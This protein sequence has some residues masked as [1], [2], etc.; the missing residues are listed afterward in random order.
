MDSR[1][2]LHDGEHLL[3]SMHSSVAALLHSIVRGLAEGLILG[4]V[5]SLVIAIALFFMNGAIAVWM[6]VIVLMLS[7]ALVIYLR[8]RSWKHGLIRVTTER[9]L[10]ASPYALFHAPLTTIKWPQY[11]ECEAGHRHFLDLFF[12]ARPLNFRYGTADAPHEAHFPSLR[13]AE[14]LKHYIDKV[15]SAFRRNETASLKPFVA[16]PRGKRDEV[17]S[18]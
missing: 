12:F 15:D 6:I 8:W 16:K 2:H 1:A 10:L 9:I 7:C 18:P 17:M 3:C 14:D 11:Q 13:Y 5:I 4:A